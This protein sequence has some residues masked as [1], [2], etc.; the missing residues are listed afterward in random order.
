M[1]GP[2]IATRL[3]LPGW[4][5]TGILLASFSCLLA[6]GCARRPQTS[7]PP[8]SETQRPLRILHWSDVRHFD[9]ARI[10]WLVDIRVANALFEGLLSYEP[11]EGRLA[12]GV[13]HLPPEISQDQRIYTFHLRSEAKWSDGSPVTAADFVWSWQRVLQPAVAAD[14]VQH[15][16]L[17]QNAEAYWLGLQGRGPAVDFE[18]VGI[19]ALDAHRLE[20]RLRASCA[21]WLDLMAFVA[22]FPVHRPSVQPFARKLPTGLLDYDSG[23]ALP[24]QLV[25][26]GPFVLAAHQRNRRIRLQR[27]LHYWDR[28]HVPSEVLEIIPVEEANAAFRIY[29]S[30]QAEIMTFS[31]PQL[32]RADLL[33]QMGVQRQDVHSVGVFGTHFFRFNTRKPPLDDPRVR[34]ALCRAVDRDKIARQ[35]LRGGQRATAFLVPAGTGDYVSPQGLGFDPAAAR[36]QL[37]DAGY[38]DG[39]ALGEIEILYN[40]Q[41]EQELIASAI[42]QMWEQNLGVRSV[43]VTQERL[44]FTDS[45]RSLNYQVARGGWFGDY[46]DPMTFLELFTSDNGN[47]DTGFAHPRYDQL[48]AKA[49]DEPDSGK[50]NQYLHQAETILVQQQCPILCLWNYAE[51]QLY[52]PQRVAGYYLNPRLR[53]PFKYVGW[54]RP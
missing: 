26:N 19:R 29:E 14:Y 35:V 37:A 40:I 49:R 51:M 39:A 10:S 13:A 32:I 46:F 54:N 18:Q 47:N 41:D 21:Y 1:V 28:E 36:E 30:R 5:P 2:A 25:G 23:W 27:N 22:F 15:F 20:V 43:L 45:L 50:R 48:I 31:P 7:L 8:A 12:E 17:I 3:S 4:L 9:P 44:V 53:N 42:K 11:T 6:A 38:T 24:G 52:D 33:Q 34:R 16:F